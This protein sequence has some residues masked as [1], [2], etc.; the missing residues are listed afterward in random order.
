VPTLTDAVQVR[1]VELVVEEAKGRVRCWQVRAAT[2]RFEVIEAGRR[3]RAAW[4]AD[5][6]LSVTPLLQQADAR[7]GC[8]ALQRDLRR[9]RAAVVV[10]NVTA[11]PA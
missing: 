2:T 3:M 4:A 1:V 5:G 11:G 9:R 7:R 8:S 10:Y 6:L